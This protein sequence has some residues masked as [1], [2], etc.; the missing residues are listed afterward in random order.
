M[1]N[2]LTSGPAN[3]DKD[4]TVV[5]IGEV[6]YPASD[7]IDKEPH[8][9]IVEHYRWTGAN[10]TELYRQLTD[11]LGTVWHCRRIVIDATGIGQP[12]ASFLKKALGHRVTPFTFS[13]ASKSELGFRLLAMVNSGRIKMYAGDGS[14]EYSEF[15]LQVDMAKRQYRPNRTIN[16]FVDPSQGHDDFLMSLALLCEAAKDFSPRTAR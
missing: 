10:H 2:T 15:C 6:D 5:T 4:S 11:I 16:F 9:N 7:G 8:V 13:S 12:V 3:P 14:P 1:S